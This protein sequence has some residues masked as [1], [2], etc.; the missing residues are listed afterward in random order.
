VIHEPEPTPTVPAVPI[1]PR[2][3]IE[4]RV[5]V[6]SRDSIQIRIEGHG[7]EPAVLS[8]TLSV[9]RKVGE[10]W[11]PITTE[12]FLRSDCDT[13]VPDCVTLIR[14]AELRP[15]IWRGMSGQG[16]CAC[17]ICIPLEAGEYR[18]VAKS[19]DQGHSIESESFA[20]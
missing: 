14:G 2:P 10:T 15:P 13:E 8:S 12:L 7:E 18:V 9:E 5:D 4:V 6:D 16:Q 3:E 17:E 20:L 11:A 1:G 19:C